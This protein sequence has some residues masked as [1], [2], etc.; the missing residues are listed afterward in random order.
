MI[1]RIAQ[2]PELDHLDPDQRAAV[3]AQLPWWTYPLMWVRAILGGFSIA[4]SACA[5]IGFACI[6]MGL[7]PDLGFLL[8]VIP[9]T[10]LAAVG[11]Y[12][13]YLRDVRENLRATIADAY[14]HE[15]P[16]FCFACGYDLRA[17]DA[18]HCPECGKL[19]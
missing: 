14:A 2:F 16:P 10:I 7:G 3:L 9:A 6:A 18:T 19:I 8:A 13:L 15:R 5:L 1:W 17:S 12:L 4:S 11:L